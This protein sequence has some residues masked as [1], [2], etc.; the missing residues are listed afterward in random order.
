[1]RRRWITRDYPTVV[2]AVFTGVTLLNSI[3]MLAGWDEPKVGAFAYLHLLGRLAIIAAVV[4]L[5]YL[6]DLWTRVRAPKGAESPELRR[7]MARFLKLM[8]DTPFTKFVYAFTVV[9]AVWCLFALALSF[10]ASLAGGSGLYR[11]LLILAGTLTAWVTASE[12]WPR[13]RQSVR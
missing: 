10:V 3:M 13:R 6:D 1:M 12:L 7:R 9:T 2:C 5:F 8:F 4:G 11:N